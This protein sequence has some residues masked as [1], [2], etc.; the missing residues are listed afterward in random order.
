MLEA[1]GLALERTPYEDECI[2][3]L[4]KVLFRL[5]SAMTL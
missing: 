2:G 1:I 5:L 4:L 3:N